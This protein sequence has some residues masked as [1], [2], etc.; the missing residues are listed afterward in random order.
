MRSEGQSCK[1]VFPK[2]C[3]PWCLFIRRNAAL[4][5]QRGYNAL[6]DCMLSQIEWHQANAETN[7]LEYLNFARK[8]AHWWN[9]RNMD[10]YIGKELDKRY[11]EYK[12]DPD[13]KRNKAV[14]D[15]VLQA[16]LPEN[17]N[18]KP[19]KLDPEFR[20]FAISQ[21]RLFMFV[22]HDS[23]SSTICYILYLLAANP[24]AL[25]Q[26]RA[27]HDK[28][29]GTDVLAAPSLLKEQAQITENLPFT[30]AVIK[31][32][33]RL[34]PPGGYSRTGNANVD[35]HDDEGNC[36]PTKDLEAIFTIHTEIHRAPAY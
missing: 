15:L 35:L 13:S 23:T 32:S 12:T 14:I 17:A 27:E 2:V 31:E 30:T 5:A 20:A 3:Q 10:A 26:V 28:V 4:N 9:G 36:Y 21:I 6:A 24:A 22:G 25:A 11:H 19:E 34:F 7:P 1:T 33:L 29:L 16:Y 18:S 8:A